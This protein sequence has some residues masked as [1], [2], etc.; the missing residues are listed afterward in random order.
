[1]TDK[2]YHAL[3]TALINGKEDDLNRRIEKRI[4][5]TILGTKCDRRMRRR[6]KEIEEELVGEN[7]VRYIKTQ[8]WEWVDHKIGKKVTNTIRRID[9]EMR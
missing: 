8:P 9:R 6:S 3:E 4:L 5:R 2:I 1:M 7:I